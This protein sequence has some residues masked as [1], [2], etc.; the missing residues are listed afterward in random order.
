MTQ[1]NM[2]EIGCDYPKCETTALIE[3]G[4]VPPKW[5]RVWDDGCHEIGRGPMDLCPAH[6]VPTCLNLAET[7]ESLWNR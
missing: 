5:L 3:P 7:W 2:H 4:R 1:K 6:V